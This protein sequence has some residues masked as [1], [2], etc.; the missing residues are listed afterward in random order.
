MPML[1]EL[2]TLVQTWGHGVLA[3]PNTSIM[4]GRWTGKPPNIV[5]LIPTMGRRAEM[6]MGALGAGRVYDQPHVQVYVRRA[7]AQAAYNDAFDLYERF[8][9]FE[10]DVLG[11]RYFLIECMQMPTSMG[12][13]ENDNL[14]QYSFNLHVRRAPGA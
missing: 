11:H 14:M 3:P 10:G 1:W 5:A 12:V 8:H 9:F 13:T 4:L 7:D 2:G 6:V